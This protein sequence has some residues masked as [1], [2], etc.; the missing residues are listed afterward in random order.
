MIDPCHSNAKLNSEWLDGFLA[1]DN[2]E[3]KLTLQS[4]AHFSSKIPTKSRNE[5]FEMMSIFDG[6]MVFNVKTFTLQLNG[7]EVI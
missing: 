5:T 4:C 7:F 1:F 2:A 3:F 6:V